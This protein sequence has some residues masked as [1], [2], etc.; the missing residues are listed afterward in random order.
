MIQQD[1]LEI[2]IYKQLEKDSDLMKVQNM[3]L[4]VEED[5]KMYP[6]SMMQSIKL[7]YIKKLQN[8]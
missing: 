1:V 5:A 3:L 6:W 4:D 8:L 2:V 7:F